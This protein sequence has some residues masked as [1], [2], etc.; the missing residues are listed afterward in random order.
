MR[1]ITVL[2]A[3]RFALAAQGFG[4]GRPTG[5][6]DVRHFRR[7]FHH[8]GL[9]QLDS[10]NVLARA[11]YLPAFSRLGPYD[12]DAFDRYTVASGEIFEGWSHVASLLPVETYPLYRHA[13]EAEPNWRALVQ[14]ET[15]HPGYV[16]AVYREVVTHGPLTISDL[17]DP[18]ARTGP[19]GGYAPGKL[20][21][22][23]LFFKG[24]LA[25]YRDRNFAKVYDLAERVIPGELLN[26]QV[27]P[28]E[29]AHRRLLLLAARH[30]GIGT[31]SDLADYY[32]IKVSTA[33]VVLD[34]LVVSGELEGIEVTGWKHPV[35]VHP[36]VTPL[37]QPQGTAL[38]SPFDPVVWYRDRTE[39]LF[40]FFYRIEIYVPEPKRVYGYYVLPFLLD[41][42]LVAR[43]DLKADRQGS[44]LLVRGA[45]AEPD[46]DRVNVARALRT[47]L[48]TMA[49]W[50]GLTEVAVADRGN[51]AAA[52][53]GA[54]TGHA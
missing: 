32:R 34:R 11:H 4:T 51:L 47:E 20:A 42:A 27:V 54:S 24:R 48:E 39:R 45:F 38:L 31:A 15:E 53:G 35:Y 19:W 6:V 30:H 50:L 13:M 33:K 37:R 52:L 40:D 3:R 14:L 2:Q 41:G 23:W 7:L 17:A 46:V 28:A 16:E 44:R 22:E 9:V 10:V 43:V 29:E 21:L 5:R 8:V 36:E 18:G 49:G 1:S 26:G 12:R 25:S